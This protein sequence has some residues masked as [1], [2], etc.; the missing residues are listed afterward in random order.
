M[1][2]PHDNR[3]RTNAFCDQ[4]PHIDTRTQARELR[5]ERVHDK[6]I[7]PRLC[8][9]LLLFLRRMNQGQTMI[10][11]IQNR[12]RMGIEGQQHGLRTPLCGPLAQQ[13]Q[14]GPVPR[15]HPVKCPDGQNRGSVR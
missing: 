9:H 11:R 2:I 10:P 15:V 8:Q 13:C 1:V 6:M 14:D 12:P 7:Q 5:G 4:L 3:L